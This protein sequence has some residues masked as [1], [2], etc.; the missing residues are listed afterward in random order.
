[1]LTFFEDS[2]MKDTLITTGVIVCI[3]LFRFIGKALFFKSKGFE[4]QESKHAIVSFL[5]WVTLYA[6]LV[7]LLLY[8]SEYAWM[9]RELFTIGDVDISL[10]LLL[11]ALFI[12][13]LANR[14]SKIFTSL[15]MPPLYDHYRLDTGL[16]FTFNRV[17]HYTLMVIA[18]IISLTTVGIDLSA[19]TI[20]AGVLGVGIGF[21]MQNIANNFIS[22]LII[23]FERPIKVGDRVI[24]NDIIGDVEKIKMRATIIRTLDNERIIMPNSYFIEEQVVNHSY[25]DNRLRLVVPIGVAYGSDVELVRDL[26]HQVAK[27]E[28]EN[29]MYVLEKPNPFV[30]FI[31]FGDS[32]LDFQLFIWISSPKAAV[33][34]KSNLNFRINR[35][36][37]ENNVEIPFPQ[38]DLHIRSVDEAVLEKL[39]K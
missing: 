8:F 22:G 6:I 38:R 18:V 9:S 13:T 24:I 21:G 28:K 31:G 19:L 12:I 23:L 3:I 26:L 14:L 17:F 33:E 4:K 36:L 25:G 35:V 15:L 1:M 10:L 11:I 7:F 20:F 2:I 34:T 16:Q 39:R 5:N 27:E 32:S 30:N 37:A 29:S